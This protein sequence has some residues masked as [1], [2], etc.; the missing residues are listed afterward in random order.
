MR[1][2]SCLWKRTW[3]KN[4]RVPWSP[5][6]AKLRDI[7]AKAAL[8]DHDVEEVLTILREAKAGEYCMQEAERHEKEAFAI[9][10]GLGVKN[11]AYEK[12]LKVSRFLV[13]RER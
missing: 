10:E 1:S 6:A 8:T 13:W 11:A 4:S 12:L 7:Y 3:V 2:S 9:L 5:K